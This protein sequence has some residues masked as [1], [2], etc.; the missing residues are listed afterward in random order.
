MGISSTSQLDV[1]PIYKLLCAKRQLF[2]DA[3]FSVKAWAPHK[4]V[5]ALDWAVK[6]ICSFLSLLHY[7]FGCGVGGGGGRRGGNIVMFREILT[8]NA[9]PAF[10]E[11]DKQFLILEDPTPLIFHNNTTLF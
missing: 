2:T 11:C 3:P 10:Y 1:I 6:G 5:H 4:N 8:Q 7:L 9:L